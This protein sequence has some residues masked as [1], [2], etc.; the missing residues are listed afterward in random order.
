M[1]IRCSALGGIMTNPKKKTEKLSAGCKTFIKDLVKEELFGYKSKIESKYLT[2]GTDVEDASI[3]LYNEVYDTLYLKNTVRL[4]NDFISGECDINGDGLIVDVKSSW[5]LETF[6]ATPQDINNKGYEWQLRG[7]MWLYE[8]PRAELAYCIVNTPDELLKN[9]DDK[10]IHK[11]D[12]IPAELR[13]TKVHFER[14]T[15]KEALIEQRVKDCR[16]FYNEYKNQ[17]LN[18]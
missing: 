7:Y 9:W 8:Q 14:D 16:E 3:D 1:K 15:E 4:E 11:V 12:R 6:P 13:I 2:K 18:K 5:S 10:S 17:I